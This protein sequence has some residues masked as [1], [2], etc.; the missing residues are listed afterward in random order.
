MAVCQ[1]CCRKLSF[2]LGP[3]VYALHESQQGTLLH[4]AQSTLTG[5]VQ[6]PGYLLSSV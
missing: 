3:R 1:I 5:I 6:T 4:S 2:F